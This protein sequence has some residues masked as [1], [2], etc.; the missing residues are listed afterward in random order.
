MTYHLRLSVCTDFEER[1]FIGQVVAKRN[2][3]I[4]ES[5][6][7]QDFKGFPSIFKYDSSRI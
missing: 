7:S 1:L 6:M 4:L 2:D 3:L 5:T